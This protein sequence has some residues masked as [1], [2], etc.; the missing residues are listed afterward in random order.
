[1][2]WLEKR[3]NVYR[4]CYREGR[5][6]RRI[7]AYTDKLASKALMGELERALAR[8]ERGL[9]DPYKEHRNRPLVKHLAD[10]IGELRQVG[11]SGV[12]AAQ[13]DCRL[14]RLIR[15]CEWK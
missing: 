8:G 1:M 7:K 4:V 15:E 3:D 12:Y 6:V 10:W 14:S 13:C 2:A 9:V 5:K 11:R